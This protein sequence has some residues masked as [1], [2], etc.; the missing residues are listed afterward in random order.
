MLPLNYR[1]DAM[2]GQH[3]MTCISFC[4]FSTAKA[5]KYGGG[6]TGFLGGGYRGT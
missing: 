6:L 4:T 2:W 1:L 3:K 5:A